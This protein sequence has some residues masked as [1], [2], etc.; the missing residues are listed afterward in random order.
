MNNLNPYRKMLNK[1]LEELFSDHKPSKARWQE[2]QILAFRS[3]NIYKFSPDLK[4]R[5]L[6]L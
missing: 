3:E 5:H 2:I 6:G 1:L 4:A